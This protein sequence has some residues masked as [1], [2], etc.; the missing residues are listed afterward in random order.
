MN[1]PADIKNLLEDLKVDPNQLSRLKDDLFIQCGTVQNA[2]RLFDLV[3]PR[4]RC[5]VFGDE[6]TLHI[7]G[8]VQ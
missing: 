1:L 3:R 4:Y 8:G 2:Q 7:P 6:L 5:S